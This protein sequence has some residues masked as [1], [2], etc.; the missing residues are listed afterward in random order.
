MLELITGALVAIAAVAL[1]LEP[2][3][4]GAHSGPLPAHDPN[5][6]EEPLELEES[7]SPKVQAL[8]ALREIEFDRA[9]GKLS[10]DDYTELKQRY[11]E[12][13]LTAI[14]E[15]EAVLDARDADTAEVDDPAERAVLQMRAA[16]ERECQSCGV[17]PETGAVFC[18]RCGR[19]L[20]SENAQ[21]RCWM[22]GADL[23]SDASYCC[24]CGFALSA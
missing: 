6:F 21:P 18:S 9:T 14:R 24:A 17:R 10:D 5:L 12:R 19:S 23:E 3:V 16:K 8:L 22:C 7:R 1:V 11:E 20:L 4:R 13:A 15:E 2:L